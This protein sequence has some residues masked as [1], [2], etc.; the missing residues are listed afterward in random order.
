M[1]RHLDDDDFCYS[2]KKMKIEHMGRKRKLDF[3][4]DQDRKHFKSS[5]DF[6]EMY[7]AVQLEKQLLENSL[8]EL[9][10]AYNIQNERLVYAQKENEFLKNNN[11]VLHNKNIF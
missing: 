4:D 6:E 2:N 5:H 8:K 3:E 7:H 11:F 9:A 10:T 1:K